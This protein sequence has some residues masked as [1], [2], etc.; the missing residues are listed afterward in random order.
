MQPGRGIAAP[1]RGQQQRE[2]IGRGGERRHG[3]F[4]RRIGVED[5]DRNQGL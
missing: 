3:W 5:R 1:R 4:L 2:A